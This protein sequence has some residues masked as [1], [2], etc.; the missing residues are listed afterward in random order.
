MKEKI[1]NLF[2]FVGS[3]WRESARGKVGVIL[4][5][6]AILFFARLFIGT[7]SV[8]SFIIDGFKLSRETAQQKA[9]QTKLDEVNRHIQLIE[10]RSPDYIEELT[11][12]YLNLGDPRV[13][14][15]K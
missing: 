10:Q 8:E 3:A 13:R 11:Q 14:I 7:A 6:F 12:K 1:K 9:E 2:A 15:L 5:L 4:A